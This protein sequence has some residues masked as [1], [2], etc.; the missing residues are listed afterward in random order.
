VLYFFIFLLGA[1]HKRRPHKIAKNW[2]PPPL[3]ALA[4]PPSPLFVR[5]HHKLRKIR[6]FFAKKC[7]RPHLKNLPPLVRKMSALDKP[8]LPSDSGRLLWTAPYCWRLRRSR[9][10]DTDIEAR[11]FLVFR[12][13]SLCYFVSWTCVQYLFFTKYASAWQSINHDTSGYLPKCK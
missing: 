8:S 3:S 5:T 9:L 4:Q 13:S 2:P 11:I 1:V 7:G 10:G 12:S 6:S